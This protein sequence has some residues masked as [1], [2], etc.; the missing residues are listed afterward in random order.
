MRLHKSASTEFQVG[1]CERLVIA[2]TE[3][4]M[5][6]EES[7]GMHIGASAAHALRSGTSPNPAVGVKFEEFSSL[8]FFPP[9]L[10]FSGL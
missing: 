7:Q 5:S 4:I 8:D 6:S 9:F 3:L 10:P 1:F 2:S